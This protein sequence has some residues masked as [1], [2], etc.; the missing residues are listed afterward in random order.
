MWFYYIKKRYIYLDYKTFESEKFAGVMM[1]TWIGCCPNAL[2]SC[3]MQFLPILCTDIQYNLQHWCVLTKTSLRKE[4]DFV[5]F[6]RWLLSVIGAHSFWIAVDAKVM[7]WLI[8]K[9]Y[10][11]YYDHNSNSMWF[12]NRKYCDSSLSNLFSIVLIWEL[13]ECFFFIRP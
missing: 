2:I 10:A 5:A 1:K 9:V 13:L 8:A 6:R 11:K 3:R 7:C 12:C 4:S